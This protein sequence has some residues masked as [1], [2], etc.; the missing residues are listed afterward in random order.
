MATL[1][2]KFK[3]SVV[4]SSGRI[5]DFTSRVAPYGDFYR[6]TNLQV[7]LSSWNNILLTPT[8]TYTY[9][10]EYGSDLYKLVFE[11][12]DDDTKKSIEDEIFFKLT[13]YDNRAEII[14][15]Q[16]DYLV[17]QKGFTVTIVADYE[18]ERGTITTQIDQ[19]LYFNI[20]GID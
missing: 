5:V 7:I 9:D 20:T 11:P 13:R 12:Q 2:E 4:G 6:V 15:L 16:I 14:D 18:G 3:K 10:P 19:S 17:N 1:I 8:R